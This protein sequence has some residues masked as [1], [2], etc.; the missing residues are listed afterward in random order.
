MSN[1]NGNKVLKAYS[2]L[3]CINLPAEVMDD[4]YN[5][6]NPKTGKHS[7]MISE[8]IHKIIQN[9]AEVCNDIGCVMF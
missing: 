8:E 3:N 2:L 7:P 4:L 5:W 1:V 6:N 9:N